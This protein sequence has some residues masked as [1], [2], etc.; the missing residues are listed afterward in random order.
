MATVKASW[1]LVNSI[2]I[3]LHKLF[4]NKIWAHSWAVEQVLPNPIWKKK[5]IFNKLSTRAVPSIDLL[6][7]EELGSFLKKNFN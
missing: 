3:S 6:T 4:L 5:V 7:L 1:Y 2:L